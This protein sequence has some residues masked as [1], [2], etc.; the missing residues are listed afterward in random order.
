MKIVVDADA[1][2]VWRIAAR[3]GR[4]RHIPVVMVSDTAHRLEGEFLHVV[5]DQGRES[6]DCR[7]ANLLQPG[8]LAITQDYGVAALALA[9]GARALA[10]AGVRRVLTAPEFPCWETLIQ[11]GLRPVESEAF[12]QALAAP[13]ALAALEWQGRPPTLACVRLSG[14]RVSAPLARAAEV[15]C[16][17]VGRLAVDAGEEGRE[18]AAWLRAEF[19]AA[20]QPPEAGGADVTLC[21][22]PDPAPG[23]TVFR[24]CGPRPDLAGFLPAPAGSSL[25]DGLDR[26]PLL[27]LLWE[28][29]RLPW[30]RVRILPPNAK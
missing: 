6:A 29:G 19:G 13:L 8:D 5:V 25:P 20:I 23:R 18:L 14:R 12:C 1:C 21:F 26:I 30:E 28:T 11:A 22:G 15:L 17:R 9:R 24:L 10:R 27:A 16:P 4:R 2:P 3:E 7:I